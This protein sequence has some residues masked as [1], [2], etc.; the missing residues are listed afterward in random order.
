M[1]RGLPPPEWS[2]VA[3]VGG[4]Y[5]FEEF[6]LVSVKCEYVGSGIVVFAVG[7]VVVGVQK[8]VEAF[9]LQSDC[10]CYCD[11][12]LGVDMLALDEGLG[13]LQFVF[14]KGGFF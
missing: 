1:V 3:V 13:Q 2:P 9:P 8:E 5:A 11:G 6:L 14:V 7:T 4:L 12:L 10:L